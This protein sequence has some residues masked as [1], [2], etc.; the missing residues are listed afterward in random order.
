MNPLKGIIP[1]HSELWAY[2][3]VTDGYMVAME[4]WLTIFLLAVPTALFTTL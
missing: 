1:M 4:R 2:L 3:S